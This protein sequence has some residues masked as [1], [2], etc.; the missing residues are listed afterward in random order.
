MDLDE[1]KALA[2][3]G[4]LEAMV[5]LGSYYSSQNNL[6]DA[7]KWFEKSYKGSVVHVRGLLYSIQTKQICL[8]TFDE[9]ANGLMVNVYDKLCNYLDA[10]VLAE[11]Y[12]DNY[13]SDEYLMI[14]NFTRSV[15][16][17]LGVAYLQKGKREYCQSGLDGF[18]KLT[19][20]CMNTDASAAETIRAKLG[21]LLAEVLLAKYDSNTDQCTAGSNLLFEYLKDDCQP[22]LKEDHKPAEERLIVM[23][24]VT[25]A[26]YIGKG[27]LTYVKP[28]IQ[29]AYNDEEIERKLNEPEKPEET[30]GKTCPNCNYV[31][32]SKAKFCR[33]CGQALPDPSKAETKNNSKKCVNCGA[34]LSQNAKFC[35][36][37][38]QAVV[39]APGYIDETEFLLQTAYYYREGKGVAENKDL[40]IEIYKKLLTDDRDNVRALNGLSWC[41]RDDE[42]DS[43]NINRWL[44]LIQKAAKLGHA[45]SQVVLAK[46]YA[47]KVEDESS[48]ASY[49]DAV[50]WYEQ[51][52][53][54]DNIEALRALG[55]IILC[56]NDSSLQDL[57]K[58]LSYLETGYSLDPDTFAP[59]LGHAYYMVDAVKDY[60]KSMRYCKEAALKGDWRAAY[61]I[62][63]MYEKGQGVE[64]DLLNAYVWYKL[65]ADNDYMDAVMG[66]ANIIIHSL[67]EKQTFKIDPDEA[68]R[69]LERASNEISCAYTTELM[70][71][72]E[73]GIFGTVDYKKADYYC[74][75]FNETIREKPEEG[76]NPDSAK[77]LLTAI[78][79]R[80]ATDY[81]AAVAKWSLAADNDIEA[82]KNAVKLFEKNIEKNADLWSLKTLIYLLM[83]EKGKHR[84]DKKDN[85]EISDG[86]TYIA[87]DNVDDPEINSI[88]EV[89]DIKKA[90]KLIDKGIAWGDGECKEI[91][92]YYC[93]KISFSSD[94]ESDKAQ[95]G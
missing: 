45:D 53:E 1:L 82:K 72:Y 16:F 64:A 39:A 78:R 23:A 41:F 46:Y 26:E 90:F 44:P 91:L 31:N 86:C 95:N 32:R 21:T 89:V 79:Q 10:A 15:L 66:L 40:S 25:A 52:I 61:R 68:V 19:E 50:Y 55:W 60:K 80:R 56:C 94:M 30:N 57:N 49:K 70:K 93:S 4:D 17:Y 38:G 18:R 37:C 74:N 81:A 71:I 59:Y 54:Q 28:Y 8:F 11:Q 73:K 14:R 22:L 3:K 35:M 48:L 75:K 13:S 76:L 7:D 92:E 2:E 77:A 9:I 84:F 29:Y 36:K 62:G 83:G 33:N 12:R 43:V 34:E 47:G 58:A 20:N 87:V 24:A 42:D 65:A 6:I 5:S 67:R 69:C 85:L 51:A 63:K 88:P 27:I